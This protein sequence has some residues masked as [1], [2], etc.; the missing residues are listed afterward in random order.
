[1]QWIQL[2]RYNFLPVYKETQVLGIIWLNTSIAKES[3]KP[4][5]SGILILTDTFRILLHF[6]SVP[7]IK[8]RVLWHAQQAL[9]TPANILLNFLKKETLMNKV[10]KP[11]M[12]NFLMVIF[13]LSNGFVLPCLWLFFNINNYFPLWT[14]HILWLL[15]FKQI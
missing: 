3:K 12:Q 5:L 8:P 10:D 7:G 11:T 15:R 4:F 1:M 9:Y 14:F 2:L 6:F 13:K